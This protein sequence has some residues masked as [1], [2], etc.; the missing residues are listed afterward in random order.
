MP[1]GFTHEMPSGETSEMA[2]C[3]E[4]LEISKV[5][6]SIDVKR[7]FVSH[8]PNPRHLRHPRIQ[9]QGHHLNCLHRIDLA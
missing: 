7:Y 9:N 3:S 8:H 6:V 4:R 5:V 2:W 1:P